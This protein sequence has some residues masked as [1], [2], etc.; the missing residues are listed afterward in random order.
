MLVR[1]TNGSSLV[2]LFPQEW[3]PEMQ[4]YWTV[5]NRISSHLSRV[6]VGEP[7]LKH[8]RIELCK[9]TSPPEEAAQNEPVIEFRPLETKIS[10]RLQSINTSMLFEG[11]YESNPVEESKFLW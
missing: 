9:E 10:V 3:E 11:L 7:R 6:L 2:M 5:M 4:L 1:D 8:W